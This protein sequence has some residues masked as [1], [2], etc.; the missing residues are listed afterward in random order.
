MRAS[1]GCGGRKGLRVFNR[2]GRF[3]LLGKFERS[4]LIA[5]HRISLKMDAE[6]DSIPLNETRLTFFSAAGPFS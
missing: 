4:K 1:R 5:I 6:M 3:S 2:L